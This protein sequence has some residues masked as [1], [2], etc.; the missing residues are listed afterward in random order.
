MFDIIFS[1]IGIIAI[2]FIVMLAIGGWKE[3]FGWAGNVIA[4]LVMILL[5]IAG[6]PFLFRY[7][8]DT[9]VS[10]KPT[11]QK[12]MHYI[13]KPIAIIIFIILLVITGFFMFAWFS[14]R[15]GALFGN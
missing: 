5:P 4:T 15:Q 3:A 1:P 14:A 10:D 8:F 9:T 2:I 13:L 11:S 6:I 12:V 7:V